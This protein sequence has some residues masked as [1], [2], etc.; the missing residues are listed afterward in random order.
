MTT[1]ADCLRYPGQPDTHT[2]A[3]LIEYFEKLAAKAAD[4]ER[5]QEVPETSLVSYPKLKLAKKAAS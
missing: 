2:R 1:K 5:V 4:R 3:E